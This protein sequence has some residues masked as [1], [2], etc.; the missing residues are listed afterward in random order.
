[1]RVDLALVHN[2][3]VLHMTPLLLLGKE[4]LSVNNHA[5]RFEIRNSQQTYEFILILNF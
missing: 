1:M 4:A 2:S 3:S 5:F